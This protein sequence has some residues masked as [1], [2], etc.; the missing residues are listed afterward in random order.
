MTEYRLKARLGISEYDV[1]A[2][3]CEEL[4][5]ADSLKLLMSQSI[6]V[7][8]EPAV[9]KGQAVKKGD[10]IGKAAEGKLSLPVFSP[11]D[12]TVI[13]VNDN[14]VTVKVTR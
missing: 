6:G 4:P 11:A 7:P 10:I 8:A 12:G 13:N 5:E 3:F 1:S 2:P 14:S 9:K